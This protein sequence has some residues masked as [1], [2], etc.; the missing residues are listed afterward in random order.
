MIHGAR[1]RQAREFRGF[2]QAQLAEK[3]N[4]DQ[5]LIAHI[6]NGTKQPSDDLLDAIADHTNFPVPFFA[7]PPDAELPMG[8]L[9]FRAHAS[10]TRKEAIEAHRLAE[11]VFLIGI[12]LI[13]KVEA[14]EPAIPLTVGDPREAAQRTRKAL[15]LSHQGPLPRIIRSLEKAGVWVLPI[16]NLA[17]RDAFSLW[18]FAGNMELPVIAVST[19][20]PGDRLRFSVAHELG[21]LVMHKELPL[22]SVNE[23]EKAADVFASEFLMPADGIYG[24]LLPP[25]TL[26][27]VARLKPK[28]GVSMQA[29]IIRAK[30]LDLISER[31]YRYLFQQLAARGWRHA[32]PSNLDVPLE[33]PRLIAKMAEVVYGTRNLAA[34]IASVLHLSEV[35]VEEILAKFTRDE[36]LAGATTLRSKVVSFPKPRGIR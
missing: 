6:E 10:L 20:R 9:M 4:R 11:I 7:S 12:H 3:V 1:I 36:D 33:R 8:S 31:Q 16:A 29:L 24:D 30:A 13:N 35:E 27:K 23:I 14:P 2:T 28:W 26:T 5:S 32:E 19:D 34:K 17:G 22:S 25:L 18:T 15:R 21:H